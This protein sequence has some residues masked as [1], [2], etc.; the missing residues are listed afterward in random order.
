[1]TKKQLVADISANPARFYRVP[2]DVIRDRRFTDGERLDILQA[3]RGRGD[4]DA[5]A[6]DAIE[7][8]MAEIHARIGHAAE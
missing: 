2:G 8:V 1:M 4:A 6:S 5:I 3:W 7:A